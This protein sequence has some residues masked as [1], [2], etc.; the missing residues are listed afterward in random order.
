M[1]RLDKVTKAYEGNTVLSGLSLELPDKGFCAVTGRSGTGKTTLL[2]IIAGLCAPDSGTV[3]S[4]DQIS[5]VFQV[6]DH[7][8]RLTKPLSRQ[9]RDCPP[10][11]R[12][13]EIEIELVQAAP[14]A[15]L[16]RPCDIVDSAPPADILDRPCDIHDAGPSSGSAQ[17][18]LASLRPVF[19]N[20]SPAMR[21]SEACQSAK[22]PCWDR[23]PRISA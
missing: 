21:F 1:I 17:P 19:G 20:A 22:A 9:S 5:M 15:T 7:C 11:T 3:Q 8:H 14:G 13:A 10:V 6:R 18:V 23:C 12:S 2:N 4:T 16:A